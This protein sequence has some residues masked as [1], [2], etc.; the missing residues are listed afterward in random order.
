MSQVKE[1]TVF[2]AAELSASARE[3]AYYNWLENALDYDWF[4]FVMD[5][6]KTIGSLMGIENMEVHF[7]GFSSQ[8]DGA[9]FTG[10]YAYAKNAPTTVKDYAPLDTELARIAKELQDAQ[11]T[12]FYQLTASITHNGRYYHENSVSFQ[13]EDGKNYYST[14]SDATEESIAE[15]LRDFMRWIYKALENEY[16]HLTSEESFLE[17]AECNEYQYTENGE[18]F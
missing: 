12:S 16:L 17:S 7:S 8:G 10:C 13:V 18:Q 6:A 4:D 9:C 14:I 3:R 2:S 1:V 15:P 5:D 11:R